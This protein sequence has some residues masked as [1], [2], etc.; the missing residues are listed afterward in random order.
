MRCFESLETLEELRPREGCKPIPGSGDIDKA[1]TLDTR[2][3]GSRYDRILKRNSRGRCPT[4]SIVIPL[5]IDREST[6]LTTSQAARRLGISPDLLRWRLRVGKYQEV[7]R[8]N[9]GRR[10]FSDTDLRK[11]ER[12]N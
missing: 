4:V 6:Y 3:F 11:M 2:V 10:K 1:V 5:K 7:R 9:V 8:D 12:E